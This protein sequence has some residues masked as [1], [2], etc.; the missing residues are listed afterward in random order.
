[1]EL[2]AETCKERND[3]VTQLFTSHISFRD[4]IAIVRTS[5]LNIPLKVKVRNR[6][7]ATQRKNFFKKT[8]TLRCVVGDDRLVVPKEKENK[9]RRLLNLSAF[10][11]GATGRT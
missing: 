10:S 9:K 6:V 7:T 8:T 1:M 2:L 3:N 11:F 5:I 4:G